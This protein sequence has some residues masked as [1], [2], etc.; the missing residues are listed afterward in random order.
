M[1]RIQ[2]F[3][4]FCFVLRVSGLGLGFPDEYEAR[5]VVS[6]LRSL[7]DAVKNP[8]VEG[9]ASGTIRS[10]ALLEEAYRQVQP[11]GREEQ[12]SLRKFVR[13]LDP[14]SSAQEASTTLRRWQLARGRLKSLGPPEAAPYETMRGLQIWSRVWSDDTSRYGPD[15]HWCG[16][17]LRSRWVNQLAL[18]TC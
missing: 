14:A 16:C 4:G 12:A 10:I 8:A 11:G 7:P 15:W 18:S 6:L 2:R 3:V 1:L 5:W 9:V 13:T 17:T